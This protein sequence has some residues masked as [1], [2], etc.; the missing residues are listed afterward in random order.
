MNMINTKALTTSLNNFK[1][2]PFDYCVIDNFFD[3]R[4]AR[5]LSRKFPKYNSQV[6]HSYKNKIEN[7]KTCNNWNNF[8][9]LTYKVFCFLNSDTFV[10]LISKKIRVN[11]ISDPGLHGGGWH[12][13]ANKGNLNPHLD[14]SIHPKMTYQRRLNLI[15]YLEESYKAS[16]G[17]HLGIWEHNHEENLPGLLKKEVFPKFNR[18]II[19]DTSQNSWHG[20]SRKIELPRNVYRKSIAIYYLCKPKKVHLN[21]K[22]ALFAPRDN[23]KKSQ[24]VLDLIKLRASDKMYHKAYMKK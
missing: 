13:H 19:F 8:D 9:E 5:E 7:K 12:I 11:L 1:K 24:D 15:V 6:W 21:N 14:Y 20:L 16:Y 4:V 23:Q 17:G 10:N 2:K 22:R 18:A 3:V